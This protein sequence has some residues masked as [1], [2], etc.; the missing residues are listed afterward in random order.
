MA[1]RC[2]KEQLAPDTLVGQV[3]SNGVKWTAEMAKHIRFY[4]KVIADDAQAAGVK[5]EDIKFETKFHLKEVDDDAYGTCDAHFG[6]AFGKLYVYDLKYGAGTPVS[7]E[8]N[9]QMQYYALGAMQDGDYS[10]VEM[11]IVQPRTEDS[12]KRWVVPVAK[13][14]QFAFELKGAVLRVKQPKTYLADGPHCKWCP[15]LAT[16]PQVSKKVV[17][18]AQQDFQ[19]TTTPL[20][21]PGALTPVQLKLVLDKAELLNDWLTA[22]ESYAKSVMEA[23]TKIEGW[24]LVPK[25]AHRKWKDEFEVETALADQGD[26]I[27]DKK[28][29]TP[30]QMEA[31]V[32][33]EKVAELSETPD[34]GLTIAKDDDG[35]QEATSDFT[36]IE[37]KQEKT[38]G[39]RKSKKS[40]DADF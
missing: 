29:K 27:Y 6:Q 7:A 40:S 31:V 38:S 34:N 20:P 17:E 3:A 21:D 10:E 25:R 37:H 35:R 4:L 11:V 24:K 2:A 13:L 22:V 5:V 33:K 12:V 9:L 8:N 1:E 15:T 18:V 39:K 32:G 14:N 26:A 36:K 23:G 16:C 30:K 28:L 19:P